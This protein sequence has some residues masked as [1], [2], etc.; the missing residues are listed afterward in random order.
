M[1]IISEIL[2]S[3]HFFA[4]LEKNQGLVY[5]IVSTGLVGFSLYIVLEFAKAKV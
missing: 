3:K 1:K 2:K 4:F 5:F